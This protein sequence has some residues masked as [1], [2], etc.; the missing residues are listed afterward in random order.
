MVSEEQSREYFVRKSGVGWELERKRM[1]GGLNG[2]GLT[3]PRIYI[4]WIF[5]L[6]HEQRGC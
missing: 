4:R 6:W 2:G 3:S 1:D 5:P